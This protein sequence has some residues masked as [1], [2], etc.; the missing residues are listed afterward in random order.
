MEARDETMPMHLDLVVNEKEPRRGV[1]ALLEMLRPNWN[2]A[3]IK[4]K[5]R[6]G[7]RNAGGLIPSS[8]LLSSVQ[9]EDRTASISRLP[10][11][12]VSFFTEGI[13][14]QLMGCYVD[15][16][17]G[18]TVLVRLYGEKTE[19]FVDREKEMETFRVLHGHGCGPE[20]YCSF[21]NGICY[22][23]VRGAVLDDSLLR[24]PAIYRLIATEMA[25]IHSIPPKNGSQVK[26]VLWEKVS[27]FLHLIQTSQGDPAAQN[28]DVVG[29]Y[30][31]SLLITIQALVRN[32]SPHIFWAFPIRRGQEEMRAWHVTSLL[33]NSGDQ[34]DEINPPL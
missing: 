32:A 11:Q 25:R 26:P 29:G 24:Q 6:A 19:L 4:L 12:D 28:G 2:P 22:E 1:L 14:N 16:V 9:L 34:L 31:C 10:A 5:A 13:T 30:V 21:R 15:S 18:D 23:F 3:D 20:L 7:P 17:L 27:D 8:E 33:E